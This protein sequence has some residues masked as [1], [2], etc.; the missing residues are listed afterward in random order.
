[1][2]AALCVVRVAFQPDIQICRLD[3]G[4]K[5]VWATLV[6]ENVQNEIQ[7]WAGI[8]AAMLDH[9]LVKSTWAPHFDGLLAGYLLHT[10]YLEVDTAA[11]SSACE[12]L[13]MKVPL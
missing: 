2:C 13:K 8:T 1:M 7:N 9:A 3:D 5:Q 10:P 6:G 11:G 12:Q 4:Q